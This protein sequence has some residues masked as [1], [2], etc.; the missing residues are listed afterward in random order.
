MKNL[1]I[2][3]CQKYFA[4]ILNFKKQE[5]TCDKEFVKLFWS[6]ILVAELWVSW[7][8]E[9]NGSTWTPF[10]T[11]TERDF[12]I[13]FLVYHLHRISYAAYIIAITEPLESLNYDLFFWV[14]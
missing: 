5:V 14:I 2:F 9:L 12:S 10:G 8:L 7:T 4:Q 3:G 13:R 1:N 6:V 11:V